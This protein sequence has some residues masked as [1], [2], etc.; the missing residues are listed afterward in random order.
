MEYIS[1]RVPKLEDM[2]KGNMKIDEFAK[3]EMKMATKQDIKG[4]ASK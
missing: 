2:I 3:L 4:M 1:L